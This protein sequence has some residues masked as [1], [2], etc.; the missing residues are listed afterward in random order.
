EDQ[1]GDKRLAAYLVPV[2]DA[3]VD[4]AALRQ[5]LGAQLPDYMVP[6]AYVVMDAL[7]ITANGKLDR[8][9]LPAPER[10]TTTAQD[11]PRTARQDVLCRLFADVLGL[12][13]VGTNDNF[14]DLGGHSLLATRLV[15]RIRTT[16]GV[17][18]GVRQLFE[19]P[20]VAALE[21]H[22]TSAR[23]ARP[24]LRARSTGNR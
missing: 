13:D 16:L 14:F 10:Q 2:D 3:T 5:D 1:P 23:P 21:P 9:A 15:N 12:P 7:P 22:L 11:T 20:T 18:V 17:E 8:N 19:N 24:T 4:V 6:T